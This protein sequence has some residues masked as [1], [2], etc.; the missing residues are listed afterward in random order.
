M[1]KGNSVKENQKEKN[2][3]GLA[4]LFKKAFQP[5][6]SSQKKCRPNHQPSWM[7]RNE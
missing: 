5:K 1:S 6:E 3:F 4:R 2:P 7:Y